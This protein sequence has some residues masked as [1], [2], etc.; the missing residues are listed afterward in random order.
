MGEAD[1]PLGQA[2]GLGKFCCRAMQKKVGASAFAA[3]NFDLTPT[4]I[5][6]SRAKRLCHRFL[7]GESCGKAV[8]LIFAVGTLTRRK[9]T[10]EETFAESFN[11]L[12]HPPIFD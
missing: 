5:A 10:V 7:R 3:A 8:R 2:H 12:S 11:A 4:Y 1:I 6:D 9:K